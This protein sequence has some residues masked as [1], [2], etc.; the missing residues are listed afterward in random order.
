MEHELAVMV[1]LLLAVASATGTWWIRKGEPDRRRRRLWWFAGGLALASVVAGLAHEF[2][3][4][5]W[6]AAF[7]VVCGL[8]AMARDRLERR[9]VL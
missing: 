6:G 5:G 2:L 8:S 1:G 7:A 9:G 4:S 3:G